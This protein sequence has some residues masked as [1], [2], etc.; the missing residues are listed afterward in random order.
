MAARKPY[1]SI[2]ENPH[3]QRVLPEGTAYAD[4]QRY[5]RWC[6]AV[7][8]F[9]SKVCGT[10]ASTDVPVTWISA[11]ALPWGNQSAI[12]FTDGETI[13]LNPEEFTAMTSEAF[14]GRSMA[15]TARS[16]MTLKA[17]ALHELSHILWTPR[18][19]ARPT[20]DIANLSRDRFFAY[21]ILE[22]CRIEMRFVAKYRPAIDYFIPLIVDYIFNG[23]KTQ[24][25][26]ETRRGFAFVLMYGRKYLPKDVMELAYKAHVDFI[27]A[28]NIPCDPKEL[29]AIHDEY[30]SFTFPAD[31]ERAIELVN[32][33]A[34]YIDRFMASAPNP[35]QPYEFGPAGG[36]P[37]GSHENISRGSGN[38]GTPKEQREDAEAAE[39]LAQENGFDPDNLGN[40]SDDA[41]PGQGSGTSGD[42]A[43][44]DAAS[45]GDPVATGKN[46]NVIGTTDDESDGGNPGADGDDAGDNGE[47]GK[48]QNTGKGKGKGND[49]QG[50]DGGGSGT[51]E[52][53]SDG[54][55][56]NPT[57]YSKSSKDSG[58]A[59]WQPGQPSLEDRLRDLAAESVRATDAD[60][61]EALKSIRK[62]MSRV[63]RNARPN[64]DGA[65]QMPVLPKMKRGSR[66]IK[67]A[68]QTIRA[69]GEDIWERGRPSGKFNAGLA[70]DAR[71]THFNVFDEWVDAGDDET[72]FEVVILLDQSG[73]MGGTMQDWA[74]QA[75]WT[76]RASFQAL[77]IPVTVIGYD[78]T[79]R[80][81]FRP[82][83][84]VPSSTY[85]VVSS[86][87]STDPTDALEWAS[88][89]F[90][91]SEAAHKLLFSITDG[92]WS[93]A[94]S[95]RELM[96]DMTKMGVKSTL[97]VLGVQSRVWVPEL[98]D[99]GPGEYLYPSITE[100]CNKTFMPVPS[101]YGHTTLLKVGDVVD[102]LPKAIAGAITKIAHEVYRP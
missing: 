68:I 21:N 46:D 65:V 84:T 40:D 25:D 100:W 4:R 42:P 53:A 102:E 35:P 51:E 96:G 79:A 56:P 94:S 48:G 52:G 36:S 39:D 54:G 31:A 86:L 8:A 1:S 13:F 64:L 20:R 61:F 60:G 63:A 90:Q 22:D 77:D 26:E 55:K 29:M 43:D 6:E 75:M 44:D 16:M 24:V 91:A 45:D 33:F 2:H 80:L 97:V 72:S 93:M 99:Y 3:E 78:D 82:T 5:D 28:H 59:S 66:L 14:L 88:G 15:S 71:G 41:E 70:M 18:S 11:A 76:I 83:D 17:A 89:I 10:I 49:S 23:M 98:Q 74:C 67:E 57:G 58:K 69:D 19:S 73:S 37:T 81:L 62:A 38:L 32:D 7:G 47:S 34:D 27:A 50:A 9:L 101:T 85:T 92:Q 12:A 95:V 30:R 87:Q